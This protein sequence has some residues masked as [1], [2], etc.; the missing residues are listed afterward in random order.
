LK[1]SKKAIDVAL[2][3]NSKK[4]SLSTDGIAALVW[5]A[6]GGFLFWQTFLLLSLGGA[7]AGG[8][9]GPAFYPRLLAVFIMLFGASLLVKDLRRRPAV[10]LSRK[11]QDPGG[12]SPDTKPDLRLSATAFGLLITYTYLLNAI[13]YLIATPLMIFGL[14][15]LMG[16]RRWWMMAVWAV[17]FSTG[18][19]FLF[20][21]MLRV[22]LPEGILQ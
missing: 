6:F 15:L 14:M 19:H 18:L 12:G 13:G 20:R 7:S 17:G 10:R 16:E 9:F 11:N 4:A 8:V 1:E 5:I 21:Y 2:S 3:Q 22:I